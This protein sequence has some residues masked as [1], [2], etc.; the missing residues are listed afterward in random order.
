MIIPKLAQLPKPVP[1]SLKILTHSE[2]L[3]ISNLIFSA[4]PDPFQWKTFPLFC[5]WNSS[6]PINRSILILVGSFFLIQLTY[7]F[8]LDPRPAIV[9]DDCSR[10]NWNLSIIRP[11]RFPI[12]K[13]EIEIAL[14][15][16]GCDHFGGGTT[17]IL[18]NME[19]PS[20]RFVASSSSRLNLLVFPNHF[21]FTWYKD[22]SI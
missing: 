22:D 15:L 21:F 16:T 11:S 9:L 3:S 6:V 4:H 10:R 8:D 14:H 13:L 18:L 7:H 19:L 20:I 1:P 5:F 12:L 2:T 17:I